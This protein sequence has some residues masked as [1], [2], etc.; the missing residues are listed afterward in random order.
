[1]KAGKEKASGELVNPK[2]EKI[3]S[4]KIINTEAE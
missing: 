2:K 1:M 3:K 4:K